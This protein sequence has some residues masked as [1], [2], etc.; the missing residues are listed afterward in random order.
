M[1]EVDKTTEVVETPAAE[2]VAVDIETPNE[3]LEEEVVEEAPQDFYAN[4][5][6]NMD[7]RVLQKLATNLVNEYK[8]DKISRKDWRRPI[9]KV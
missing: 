9:L 6:E 2:E 7:T 8:I 5:A 3:N 4:L 1:A